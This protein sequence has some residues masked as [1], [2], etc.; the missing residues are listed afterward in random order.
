VI[1]VVEN[2]KSMS[3]MDQAADPWYFVANPEGLPTGRAAMIG[4]ADPRRHHDLVGQIR[5]EIGAF[6][7]AGTIVNA[8]SMMTDLETEMR[9]WRLGATLFTAMGILALLVAAVGVY[10]VIAYSVS[11]RAHEMGVRIALGARLG[12]IA[13]LVVGEGLRTIAIGIAAGIALALAAGKLIASL[14]YG[15]SPRD[16]AV[17]IGAAVILALIGIAASVIPALRAARVEP[18]TALRVD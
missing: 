10:S 16:P 8:R 11:Q 6:V 17:M 13:R 2:T 14:L 3:I 18:A 7:P 5:A 1:G 4:R 15:I 9:P 12:D